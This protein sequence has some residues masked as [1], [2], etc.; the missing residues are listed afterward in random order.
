MGRHQRDKQEIQRKYEPSKALSPAGT[1]NV[2]VL[3]LRIYQVGV[4]PNV[5]RHQRTPERYERERAPIQQA[6]AAEIAAVGPAVIA[7]QIGCA[8]EITGYRQ[9][10]HGGYPSQIQPQQGAIE[11]LKLVENA[12]VS[13]PKDADNGKGEEKGDDLARIVR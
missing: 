8:I 10:C 4:S 12:V 11:E 2:R 13:P 7:L 1:E 5:P 3:N 9:K 6:G